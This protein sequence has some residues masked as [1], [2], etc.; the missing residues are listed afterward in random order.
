M[1]INIRKVFSCLAVVI[2]VSVLPEFSIP[3]Q[4]N[5]HGYPVKIQTRIISGQVT[6]NQAKLSAILVVD[7][8]YLAVCTEDVW[9]CSVEINAANDEKY[10]SMPIGDIHIKEIKYPY[11][12]SVTVTDLNENTDYRLYLNFE[13]TMPEGSVIFRGNPVKF[14]TVFPKL[15]SGITNLELK[16]KNIQINWYIQN[17]SSRKYVTKFF[18][19][20]SKKDILYDSC[21]YAVP[22]DIENVYRDGE[23]QTNLP[24]SLFKPNYDYLIC[25]LIVDQDGELING[26][27][28]QFELDQK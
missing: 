20:Y 9:K 28:A 24:L 6:H 26:G 25:L 23:F 8:Q 4:A 22:I 5:G 27:Y 12:F 1:R 3:C 2:V 21:A 16:Q 18:R 13:K 19:I 7:P 15:K 14:K 17:I 11:R 10:Q